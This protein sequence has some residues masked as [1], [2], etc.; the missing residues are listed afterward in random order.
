MRRR[1]LRKKLQQIGDTGAVEILKVI[2]HDEIGHVAVG[3]RWFAFLCTQR[4]LDP[5]VTFRDALREYDIPPPRLPINLAARRQ[6]GFSELE[7]AW[8]ST[9][10][11]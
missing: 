5:A 2:A 10:A 7:L 1:R 4:G 11:V 3:S 9:P 8:L 6:G